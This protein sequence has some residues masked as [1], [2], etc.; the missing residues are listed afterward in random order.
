MVAA[1]PW[2]LLV[3]SWVA[4][5]DDVTSRAD[6]LDVPTGVDV[7]DG[8]VSDADPT[9]DVTTGVEVDGATSPDV[10]PDAS[11]DATVTAPDVDDDTGAATTDAGEVETSE[12]CPAAPAAPCEVTNTLGTCVGAWTC[13][14]AAWT[15]DARTPATEV[16]DGVD[17]D[18]DGA[19]D[20]GFKDPVTGLYDRDDACGSCA[21]D[22]TV[23][24][25]PDEHAYGR[26][27][28]GGGA[29]TCALVCCSAADPHA[30]CDGSDWGDDN[31]QPGDGCEVRV[32]R[33]CDDEGDCAQG[34]R[35]VDRICVP[36]LPGGPCV[37]NADCAPGDA[38]FGG[39]C[40]CAGE[41]YA[42]DAV[43]P[44]VLIVLDRSSS[45]NQVIGEWDRSKWDLA[46]DAVR[47]LTEAFDDRVRF[48]LQLFPGI[49]Q[50][51]TRGPNACGPGAV[52]VDTGPDNAQ[53]INDFLAGA[54]TSSGTPIAEAL[55]S[56][57]D[58]DGL[59]D[60]T[61][62]NYVVLVTDGES[63]CDP[64][65][66]EVEELLAEVPSI[67]TFVIGFGGEVDPDE[68]N[69]MA[70]AGGTALPGD[71]KYYQA[72]D[73]LSL[74]AALDT[75][76]GSVLGCTYALQGVPP[77][78]EGLGVYFDTIAQPFD[79][80][81]ENGWDYDLVSNRVTLHGAACG[82]VLDGEVDDLAIVYGCPRPIIV[83]P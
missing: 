30:S 77:G 60:A 73:P 7:S 80:S 39:V 47:S 36:N 43:P 62:A 65:S 78:L 46:K 22:C 20:D 4:C 35:C 59:E 82:E 23:G 24:L 38:C 57:V 44:N 12:P 54:G 55:R 31:G 67:R 66:P 72:D 27:D 5:G 68:L 61:R 17:N 74:G 21:T 6:A 33:P 70:E 18:C 69:A 63:S 48:G 25:G 51:G 75:I 64:P 37:V 58:Y 56:L 34:E 76:V 71:T 2:V 42:A 28:V 53:A 83:G 45:M 29:P 49:D 13:S 19:T 26:C 9:T 40:G 32:V 50:A 16:C 14:G 52:W 15:C 81:H 11:D 3:A 41:S 79:P 1:A 10:T 8:D